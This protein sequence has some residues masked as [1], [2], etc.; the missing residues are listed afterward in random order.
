MKIMHRAHVPTTLLVLGVVLALFV[1][2]HLCFGRRK[3][4]REDY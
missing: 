1:L 4:R 3:V 2:Y